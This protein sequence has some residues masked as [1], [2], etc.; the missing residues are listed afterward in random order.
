MVGSPTNLFR[1]SL[2]TVEQTLVGVSSTVAIKSITITNTIMKDT[3]VTL[4]VGGITLIP[5]ALIPPK[6]VVSFKLDEVVNTAN[7]LTGF[8]DKL[9]VNVS[10]NG[11]LIS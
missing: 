1:G 11:A 6:S 7:N 3:T 8:A 9:G 10:I 5:D 4:K 2:D